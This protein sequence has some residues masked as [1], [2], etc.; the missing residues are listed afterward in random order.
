VSAAD[1]D[2]ERWLLREYPLRDALREGR[3]ADAVVEKC[4]QLGGGVT[5]VELKD[6]LG[7]YMDVRGTW[8]W[9]IAPNTIL[10]ADM[11]E[12]FLDV[13]TAARPRL[14]IAP[15]AW[16]VY[17]IDGGLLRLPIAKRVPKAGYKTEHWLPV[18]FRAK[19]ATP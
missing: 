15:A 10:W 18:C 14:D 13:M 1:D 6:M 2:D 9:E 19:E 4:R 12:Q 16:L 7:R 17:A 8:A 5:F 3:W 11:S